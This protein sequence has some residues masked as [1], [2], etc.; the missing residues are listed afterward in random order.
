M[1]EHPNTQV[2]VL[3][4]ELGTP[5]KGASPF[6]RN[7]LWELYAALARG[8]EKV[9]FICLWDRKEGE[10]TGGTR[11]MHDTVLKYSGQVHVLDTTTLW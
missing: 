2:L 10:G 11:H 5:P 6:A 3:P 1:K 9:R 7:N 4:Q 8:P